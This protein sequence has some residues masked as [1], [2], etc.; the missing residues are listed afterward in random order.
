[1]QKY[2]NGD[3]VDLTPEEI[4]EY[5]AAQNVIPTVPSVVSMFQARAVL[6]Q[7]GLFE[8]VDAALQIAG[9]ISLQAWEYATE[10]RRDSALVNGIAE[11]L[12]LT[13]QQID[14]LFRTAATITV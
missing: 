5:E 4:G 10:V 7:A 12:E 14:D 3:L 1:M 11:Q 8:T 6:W 9:G 13:E 2:L